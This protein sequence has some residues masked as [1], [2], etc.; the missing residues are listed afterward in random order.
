MTDLI[1]LAERVDRFI[2]RKDGEWAFIYVD[3]DTGVFSCYSSFGTYAYCWT[4]IGERTLKEFLTNLDFGYFMGKT[5]KEYLRFDP[6]ATVRG[7]KDYI[8]EQRQGGSLTRDEA[9]SAWSDAEDLWH[10]NAAEFFNDL[11]S[12]NALM[13]LYGGDYCDIARERPD[14]DSRGFWKIIWPEFTAA[15]LRAIEAHRGQQ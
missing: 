7:I 8:I 13:D 15:A 3:E 2:I 6:E 1:R 12:S 9:R 5:R 14:S 10:G 11:C 4:H